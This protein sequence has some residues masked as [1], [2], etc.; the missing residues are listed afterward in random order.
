MIE[1][2]NIGDVEMGI[3][4]KNERERD[5]RIVEELTREA[6]W[7]LYVPG[8]NEHFILHNLRNNVDFIPELDCIAEKEGQIVGQIVYS[9]AKIVDTQGIAR[10]V[11]TFG[12]VS[13][14]PE[15]QK[16]G[17]GS[18]LI[19]HTIS[20][21]RDMSYPAICIYGDPRYYSRFGFRCGE[22]YD[23]KTA[24]DKYAVA[25]LAMELKQGALNNMTG[26]FIESTVFEV[27]ENKL[28][29]YDATFTFKEKTETESQRDFRI[30]ASLRY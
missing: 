11:I 9:R 7:N 6:F 26:R 14:L 16:Q 22:K 17:I 1:I 10:E 12:P 15:F 30:M 18:A 4:I 27:D 25:L 23:I 21:A 20:I 28:I 8:C 13:V 2:V 5:Y 24:D 29:E 3:L 19:N